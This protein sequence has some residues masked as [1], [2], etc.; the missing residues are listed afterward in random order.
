MDKLII[1]VAL[2]GMVPMK[3]DTPH[4]PITAQEIAEDVRRCRDLGASV[5]HIHA[6]DER[7]I[8]TY[9]KD[10]HQEVLRAVRST[11]PDAVLCVS[12]SGR[13]FKSFEE[14]SEVLDAEAPRPEMASLT[15]GSMNFAR[16]A[17][18]NSPHMI[19]SLALRMQE[20]RITP[21]MECFDL[22]MVE[23]SHYLIEKRI[24]RPPFYCNIL[25]G[26]L[27]TLS[28]TPFNLAAAVRAL[29]DGTTWAAAGIGKFQFPMN[30]LA[31][32]MGGHVRVGIEDNIWYDDDRTRLATNPDLVE[33]LVQLAGA[34]G[35][36]PA[37]PAEARQIIGLRERDSDEG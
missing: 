11:C 7:S 4:V 1:N 25:L 8:P 31:I 28:A 29:P 34:T 5:F 21:E 27:G 6:R 3:A 10:A 9:G 24:L 30:A 14:R 20:R 2:T 16:E 23:Y 18:V 15:L 35:R 17:S 36:D 13:T 19:K 22:G 26:S 37:T 33:R 32:T 12:T